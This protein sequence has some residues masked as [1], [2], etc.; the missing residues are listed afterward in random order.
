[1]FA[2]E[3]RE[4]CSLEFVL[5]PERLFGNASY[6]MTL[7]LGDDATE[8][9]SRWRLLV[10]EDCDELIRADA[11]AGTGQA[12]S[13]LLNLTDGMIGQGMRVL[14]AISTNEP[15]GRLHPAI[16]RA[17]RCIAEVEV[18]LLSPEES[19]QWLGRQA[20][21]GSFR[22]HEPCQSLGDGKRTRGRSKP[23]FRSRDRA[24]SLVLDL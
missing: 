15:L 5:D 3:W 20:G 11:K 10:L 8:D 17:G 6:P 22:R 24:I 14:V 12:L 2:H 4:W 21:I 9:D 1:M 13:R 7:V 18:G 16:A 23:P 19:R